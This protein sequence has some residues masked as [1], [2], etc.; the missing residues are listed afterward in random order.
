MIVWIVV[1]PLFTLEN[2]RS[3]SASLMA[4]KAERDVS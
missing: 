2:D 3:A 1:K 4:L